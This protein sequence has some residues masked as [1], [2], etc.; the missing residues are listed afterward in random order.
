M[1]VYTA[2]GFKCRCLS[3]VFQILE[4]SDFA[5]SEKSG[6]LFAKPHRENKINILILHHSLIPSLCLSPNSNLLPPNPSSP[7]RTPHAA[8]PAMAAV[9]F[10]HLMIPLLDVGVAR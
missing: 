7:P 8:V 4:E 6:C 10:N 1:E 3:E 2:Q 9:R 5:A